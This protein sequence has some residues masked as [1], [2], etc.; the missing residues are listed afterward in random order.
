MTTLLQCELKPS[1]SLRHSQW[2]LHVLALLGLALADLPWPAR[3]LGAVL[4]VISLW[5]LQ[6]TQAAV[7]LRCQADGR[8][9]I[10]QDQDWQA[11]ELLPGSVVWPGCCVL[12]LRG[13]AHRH[14]LTVLSDSLEAETFRRLRVWLRWRAAVPRRPGRNGPPAAAAR[15]R[16]RT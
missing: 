5:R 10:G 3:A 16:D 15:S 8:L 1:R 7:A 13:A 12:R 2:A 4:V 9:E 14:T 6:Q 11:V